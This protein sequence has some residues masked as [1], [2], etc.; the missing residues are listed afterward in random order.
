M[1]LRITHIRLQPGY[2]DHEHIV[3]YRWVNRETGAQGDSD[4]PAMVAWIDD[5]GVAY[6]EQGGSRVRVGVVRP[7]GR[8][9]YL[10][11]YA[12]ETWTDNLLS[13]PRF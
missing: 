8:Q 11:T 2:S 3:M 9:P 12:N 13:L 6:V 10:R 4:K 1:S 5:G 7:S